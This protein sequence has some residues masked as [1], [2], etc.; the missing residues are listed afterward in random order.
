MRD[1]R[2]LMAI[3]DNEL[4]N[5]LHPKEKSRLILALLIALPATFGAA[6]VIFMSAGIAL[7]AISFIWITLVITLQIL[8]ATLIGGSVKVSPNNFPEIHQ[9]LLEVKTRLNYTQNVDIYIVEDGT[10]NALLCNLFKTRFILLNSAMVVSMPPAQCRSQLVW[11]IGRFVGA[12]KAKHSRLEPLSIIIDGLEKIKIF[13]LFILPYERAIQYSGDQI[14]LALSNDLGG[15]IDVFNKLLIGKDLAKEVQLKGLLMQAKELQS[16]FFGWLSKI[17]S[18]HPHLTD[19]YLN[20][21]AF[22]KYK[23]PDDFRRYIEKLDSTT[24]AEINALLP[25]HFPTSS[26]TNVN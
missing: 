11:I 24:A 1:E 6:A 13:N 15:A 26:S 18:T 3:P 2:V 21:M 14:G 22:A 7:A 16:S 8:K 10:V 4:K 9:V 23:Y 19:R 5:L 17:L 25:K 12:I 20:L